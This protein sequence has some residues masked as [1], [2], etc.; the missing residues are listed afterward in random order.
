VS[1][2]VPEVRPS[3]PAVGLNLVQFPAHLLAQAATTA[4][5]LG[6]E[7]VWLGEHVAV[8]VQIE[9][10]YPGARRPFDIDSPFLEPLSALSHLA[11]VTSR[12]RLG[13]S[14]LLLPARDLIFTARAMITV[15][16]LSGGRLE[17]GLGA[18]WMRE[19]FEVAQRDFRRRG[20]RM[21]EMV[22]ALRRLSTEQRPEFHGE[23]VDFPPIGFE[24]KPPRPGGLRLHLGGGSD[25]AV[26]R[27][28]RW[29]D[30]WLGGSGTTEDELPGLVA[31]LRAE[32]AAAGLADRPL[33]LSL[34][35]YE[36]LDAAGLR[37]LAGLGIARVVLAPW[38]RDV[39]PGAATSVAGVAELGERIGLRPVARP[40]NEGD[41]CPTTS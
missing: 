21:E 35:R 12:I 22:A 27:A 1:L 15:D 23:F 9:S 24:P 11:A 26:R 33:E 25:R 8:P 2:A 40:D 39:H 3:S 28:A 38:G 5:S 37:W 13:T 18:G 30:G 34:M 6:F 16:V 7:S 19:G 14:V 10:T 41:T 20:A 4:E 36:P 29:A 17:F 31:R 32:R